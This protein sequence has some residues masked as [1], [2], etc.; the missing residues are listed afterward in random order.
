VTSPEMVSYADQRI[1]S[2]AEFVNSMVGSLRDVD[3]CIKGSDSSLETLALSDLL[4]ACYV[5]N[6]SHPETTCDA[7]AL[8]LRRLASR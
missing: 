6:G 4:L 7:L 5:K 1:A 2:A 8:A 3:A